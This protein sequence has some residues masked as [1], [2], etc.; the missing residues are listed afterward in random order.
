MKTVHSFDISNLNPIFNFVLKGVRQ[1]DR[2]DVK[3]ESI[4]RI[5]TALD[6]DAIKKDVFTFAHTVVKRTVFDYYRKKNRKIS[7]ASVLVNYCDGADEEVGSSVDYFTFR[8]EE[9]GYLITEVRH[10]YIN[11]ISEFTPQERK[12]INYMLFTEEGMG[13]R[14]SEISN[15]LGV[16]KSHA[17]R[18]MSKLRKVCQSE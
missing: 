3:S 15:K 13:M 11:H 9:V 10:D 16:N 6:N 18:A 4:V 2:E 7:K 14:P 5:L 17:S 8:T 1:V 12:V